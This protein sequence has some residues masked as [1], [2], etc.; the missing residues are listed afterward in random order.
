VVGAPPHVIGRVPG[1]AALALAAA[2]LAACQSVQ[3]AGPDSGS[4]RSVSALSDLR[5]LVVA[6]EDTG[7]GY[8]RSAFGQ[9]WADTDGNGCDT[10]NDV[11]ARDL[12]QVRKRG[13]CTVVSGILVDP[14]TG[15]MV[16]FSK[17]HA[18]HVQIDH[19]VSLAEAWRSGAERWTDQRR[20]AF[21]ND[22]DELLSTAAVVNDEKS[23]E[24]PGQRQP[25]TAAGRCR[26]ARTVVTVKVTYGLTADQ[27]EREAL[28][29]DLAGCQ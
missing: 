27:R 12:T 9:R 15:Q 4:V 24:D 17:A 26:Y 22:L 13:R 25:P 21:A 3:A 10:R 23:D 29:R 18:D 20:Q 28:I 1:P 14:Y 6:P 16:A 11:L 19:V 5:Q 2:V 8:R 7:A